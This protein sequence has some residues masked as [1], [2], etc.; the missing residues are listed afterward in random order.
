MMN[1]QA[2][3]A[4]LQSAAA[5]ELADLLK[6][7]TNDEKSLPELAAA[8]RRQKEAIFGKSVYLRGL[9]EISSYCRNDCYYCGLRCSNKNAVRYRLDDK[10]I[11]NCCRSAYALGLRTL[12]LQGG[13]DAAFND[14]RLCRLIERIK[15]DCDLCAITLSLGERSRDSYAALKAAGADRY[16]LREETADARHYTLL[17]PMQ[18]SHS[19][20]LRCLWDLK[21]LGYQV[22]AGFMVGSPFQTP[23][24]LAQELVFLRELQPQMIGIGPFIPQHDTVFAA[25][26]QGKTSLTLLVLALLRLLLP[27]ALLPATTALNSADEDGRRQALLGGAN[28]LMPNISPL[29][30]RPHYAI[31]DNKKSLGCESIDKLDELTRLLQE[32]GL[33]ADFARGDHPDWL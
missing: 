30:H 33:C 14:D 29:R 3:A 28:V 11:L 19:K 10:E 15:T 17:H 24:T 2:V 16:L 23:Q 9:L 22:G 25:C 4:Y 27:Q 21:E 1:T 5:H 31:Y 20:R 32:W 6:E 18:M 12:V 26:P 8:A 7:L 13:E